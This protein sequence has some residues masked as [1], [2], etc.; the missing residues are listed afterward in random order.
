MR[1]E[2]RRE[3]A[4]ETTVDCVTSLKKPV[5][6]SFRQCELAR[7]FAKRLVIDVVRIFL[8]MKYSL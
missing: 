2:K 5:D 8:V 7:S 3:G 4:D 1:E 6:T